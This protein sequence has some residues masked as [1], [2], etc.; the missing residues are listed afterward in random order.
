MKKATIVIA[1]FLFLACF[2]FYRSAEARSAWVSYGAYGENAY[3][4]TFWCIGFSSPSPS[5]QTN[6]RITVVLQDYTGSVSSP[7][8][9]FHVIASGDTYFML[10]L[11]DYA[12]FL[13]NTASPTNDGVKHIVVV[14]SAQDDNGNPDTTSAEPLFISGV[15][16]NFTAGTA[17]DVKPFIFWQGTYAPDVQETE[18]FVAETSGITTSQV[19][20]FNID[21]ANSLSDLYC[22]ILT[23]HPYLASC[24]G[25]AT[26][27][28]YEQDTQPPYTDC[29]HLSSGGI[30]V[31]HLLNVIEVGG[32]TGITIP[33]YSSWIKG[34]MSYC[35][36]LHG[37][38]IVT[39]SN[40]ADSLPIRTCTSYD[41]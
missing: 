8:L 17:W 2:G 24:G 14:F 23:H 26:F 35:G 13:T 16:I 41:E 30:V 10:C 40:W 28:A 15:Q 34:T 31:Y 18:F 11:A 6:Y 38:V 22:D 33:S 12:S 4:D 25:S 27:Y 29:F 1:A 39:G 19:M 9:N 37:F 7:I 3:I 36:I 21:P 20:L 32:Y 5:S